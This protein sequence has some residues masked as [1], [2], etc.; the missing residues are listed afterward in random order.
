LILIGEPEAT[1][2][3]G[4]RIAVE[5]LLNESS[6]F[7]RQPIRMSCESRGSDQHNFEYDF[8]APD[9]PTITD[10]RVSLQAHYPVRTAVLFSRHR[11]YA[12]RAEDN[13]R[14]V[15]PL[16]PA[17]RGAERYPERPEPRPDPRDAGMRT[18]RRLEPMDDPRGGAPAEPRAPRDR[19]APWESPRRSDDRPP[20]D[21]P[22][23]P[24]PR[25]RRLE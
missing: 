15:E 6:G 20:E 11:F 25:R 19:P 24:P 16:P 22:P 14:P 18:P 2:E 5:I 3:K 21:E 12:H 7:R 9:V 8:E 13:I 23:A 10:I 1:F 4:T 17:E